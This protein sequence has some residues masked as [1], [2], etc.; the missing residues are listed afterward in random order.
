MMN[1]YR[2]SEGHDHWTRNAAIIIVAVFVVMGI[3]MLVSCTNDKHETSAT[4]PQQISEDAPLFVNMGNQLELNG[5][6][7]TAAEIFDSHDEIS[8]KYT[9]TFLVDRITR[10]VYIKW[11]SH[12]SQSSVGGLVKTDYTYE[13]ELTVA[14]TRIPDISKTN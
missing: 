2:E 4:L 1:M 7:V 8:V 11:D 10:T 3:L 14:G 9:Y 5:Y 6:T 13:G 12:E